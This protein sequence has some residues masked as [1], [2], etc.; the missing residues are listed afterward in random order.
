M[1]FLRTLIIF[2][3]FIIPFKRIFA[4]EKKM[5]KIP[6][7]EFIMGGDVGGDS[8]SK[9]VALPKHK[10]K[11]RAFLIDRF[12]VTQGE[13]KKL[14]G[15]NPSA[16]KKRVD[17][18]KLLKNGKKIS[19]PFGPIGDN[20][21]VD[22]VN[23]YDAVK[24]CNSRSKKEGLT[25]CY[26]EKNWE[27]DYSK[28]GY[29]LP[30]EAEWEYACRAGSKSKYFFGD[31]RTKLFEYANFWPDKEA[32]EKLALKKGYLDVRAIKWDKGY[33]R[34]QPVGQKK[35][36]KWGLY[37]MLGNAS[38]WCNDWWDRNYYKNSPYKNPVGPKKGEF[39]V[40]R[41]K[42]YSSYDPQ[43]AERGYCE[44]ENPGAGFRCVRNAPKAKQTKENKTK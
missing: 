43:C 41:G 22:N 4:E 32:W 33:P 19:R 8:Y 39:K 34:L 10:V 36:N 17:L 1:K 26:N 16:T 25:P 6:T 9:N 28:N 5:V 23:W 13:F 44:A 20:F 31:D 38:E 12:E 30:T 14:L 3:A 42:S 24:Y 7:G 37:D 21:P 35:P 27:C 2:F 18:T 29:R 15:K 11:I 40:T